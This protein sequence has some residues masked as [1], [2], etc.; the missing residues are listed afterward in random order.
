MNTSLGDFG[1]S[2]LLTLSLIKFARLLDVFITHLQLLDL[3]EFSKYCHNHQSKEPRSTETFNAGPTASAWR[4]QMQP[5]RKVRGTQ[6]ARSRS[7]ECMPDIKN[8]PALKVAV[9]K[10]AQ[11]SA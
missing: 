1:A 5:K 7:S 4:L 10:R 6:C 11:Q 8:D 3:G 9:Q 2:T